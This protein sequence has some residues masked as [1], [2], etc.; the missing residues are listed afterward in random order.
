MGFDTYAL[1]AVAVMSAVTIFLRV[2]PFLVFKDRETPP[3]ISFLGKYLPYSIMGM[4]VIYCLK[5]ISL[6][7]P[8][9][10]AA[11]LAAAVFTAALYVFKRNTLF[12][13]AGGTVFYMLLLRLLG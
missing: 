1:S 9:I 4:L 10:S 3:Y 8:A 5:D 7:E 13:I 6:A 2:I 12:G 11:A